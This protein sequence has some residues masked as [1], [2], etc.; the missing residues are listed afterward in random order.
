MLKWLKRRLKDKWVQIEVS[1]VPAEI[2][3]IAEDLETYEG[4]KKEE[5]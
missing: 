3:N 2:E 5:E 1:E 4:V